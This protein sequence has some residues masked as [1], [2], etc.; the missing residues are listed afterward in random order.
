[1]WNAFVERRRF[2]SGIARFLAAA[3]ILSSRVLREA[4]ERWPSAS[5]AAG[6]S[7][8]HCYLLTLPAAGAT[9]NACLLLPATAETPPAEAVLR[10]ALCDYERAC[11][12]ARALAAGGQILLVVDGL[13][14]RGGSGSFASPAARRRA[15]DAI[16]ESERAADHAAARRYLR[17]LAPFHGKQAS[18]A[19][20]ANSAARPP[21]RHR[22]TES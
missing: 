19:A 8:T 14:R 4:Q 20:G 17:R 13:S 9:L 6:T 7:D 3:P 22:D 16:S 18:D 15:L 10:Y 2:L 21:E 1:M 12:E 11:E 5:D